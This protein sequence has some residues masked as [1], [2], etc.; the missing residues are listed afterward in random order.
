MLAKESFGEPILIPKIAD[1]N[2]S[3]ST[4]IPAGHTLFNI[5]FDNNY[6]KPGDIVDISGVFNIARNKTP[7]VRTVLRDVQV[8]AI[9]GN[10]NRDIENKGGK[11][12]IFQLLIKQ[13]QH[14]ALLL[15]SNIGK[16]EL[17]LRPL[18]GDGEVKGIAD[19]GESFL[20]W[21]R[22]NNADPEAEEV[23]SALPPLTT[24]VQ[25]PV[26]AEPAVKPSNKH[27]ILVVTPHGITRYEY[28]GNELPRE[29]KAEVDQ[30]PS[31]YPS[32]YPGNPWGSSSGYGGYAPTYPTASASTPGTTSSA[33][34]SSGE[35][36]A[37]G[38]TA[39]EPTA[40]PGRKSMFD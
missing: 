21:A 18:G 33:A 5:S 38:S 10:S 31:N 11:G 32:N 14:Q 4:Q 24:L 15:A 28:V 29:V 34:P 13:N 17:N 19:D 3:L 25:A 23:V 8:F 35:A 30:R 27:E 9:N 7:E 12:T 2:S 37:S 1:S 39:A 40:A 16:L 22:E 36:A 26:V 20:T 6:I